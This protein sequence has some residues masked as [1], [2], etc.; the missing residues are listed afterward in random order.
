MYISQK[1]NAGPTEGSRKTE[2]DR[3]DSDFYFQCSRLSTRGLW[4]PENTAIIEK[5]LLFWLSDFLPGPCL[6]AEEYRRLFFPSD[7]IFSSAKHDKQYS[8][9]LLYNFYMIFLSKNLK[10][11]GP[12]NWT[13][14]FLF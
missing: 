3:M 1:L 11:Y 5:I 6:F 4:H 14:S 12:G 8:V 7:M 13:V 2:A 10:V 9:I